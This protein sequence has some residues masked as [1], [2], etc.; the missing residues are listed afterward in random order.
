[1]ARIY[2]WNVGE[3]VWQRNTYDLKELKA[4]SLKAGRQSRGCQSCNHKDGGMNAANSHASGKKVL[5]QLNLQRR[6]QPWL[7][8]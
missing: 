8:S 5:P 3:A 7:T 6:T 4:L 1:M 2:K